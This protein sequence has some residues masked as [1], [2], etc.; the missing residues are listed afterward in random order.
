MYVLACSGCHSKTPQTRWPEQ[1][2]FISSQLWGLEVQDE[3][4]RSF[5]FF[6]G[7]SPWLVDGRLLPVFS[8]GLSSIWVCPSYLSISSFC[9]NTSQS[10]LG[11]PWWPHFKLIFKGPTPKYSHMVSYSHGASI[12]E[13]GGAGWRGGMTQFSPCAMRTLF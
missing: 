3:G 11:P 4:V 7:L 13:F 12:C 10:G 5:G 9:K 2:I 1:Q 6:R 8:H